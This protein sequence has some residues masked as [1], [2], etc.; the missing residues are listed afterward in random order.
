MKAFR[1][2]GRSIRDAFK[3]VFRNFSLSMASILCAT[4]TLLVV[5]ISLIIAGNVN[6]ATKDLESELSIVVYLEKD[7][8]EED[9][10]FLKSAIEKVDGVNTVVYKSKNEW[11]LEMSEYN[12]SIGI[13]FDSYEDN[14]LLDSFTV[15]VNDVK[16]LDSISESIRKMDKVESANYGE[17]TVDTLVSVFD[18]VEKATIVVVIALIFV[19]AFLITNTIKLTIY[20]R[21]N[22][23]EIMRLVG[24]SNTAIKLPFV[25]E[26]FIIGILG[27]LIPVIITI[28]GYIIAYEKLNGHILTDL[29][30]LINPYNFIFYI[31]LIVIGL[32]A[33]IGM[34][35]S[36][37]AVR[38]YLKI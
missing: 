21:R 20:S 25:F 8:N 15:T 9:A 33:L 32:G 19:T 4:I 34:F 10:N 22:E 30:S 27:S 17:D 23:I 11:K 16:S 1:I 5:S 12:S 37:R 7:A 14:P 13:I 6:S 31:A 29:I 18:V 35:G 36:L 24:A 2:I 28:Y 26:G 38:K 3:S